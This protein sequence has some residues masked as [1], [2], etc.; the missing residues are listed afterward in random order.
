MFFF[1]NLI[2]SKLSFR[3]L[4]IN[5]GDIYREQRSKYDFVSKFSSEKILDITFGKFFD[6]TKSELLLSR[7]IKEVWSLDLLDN[8]Q[9][10]TVRKLNNGKKIC[11][12]KKDINELDHTK[13]DVIFSFNI[14]RVT[15][16]IE[17]LLKIIKNCLL[18]EGIVVI[19]ILNTDVFLDSDN[20]LNSSKQKLLLINDFKKTLKLFFSDV[21]FHSQGNSVQLKKFTENVTSK[22][23]MVTTKSSIKRNIKKFFKINKKLTSFYLKYILTLFQYYK[24]FRRARKL[25]IDPEKYNILPLDEK[26]L[27]VSIIAV[28]KKII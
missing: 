22:N 13:F 11:Y 25:K 26:R 2:L 6:F 23:M 14:M 28:C 3:I 17:S 5:I 19:S 15:E 16:N 20:S 7:G 21:S 24:N 8:D 12:Q 4:E 1:S 10:L 27:P 18:D 9:Y